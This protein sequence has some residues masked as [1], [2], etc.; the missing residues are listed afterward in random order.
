M[1]GGRKMILVWCGSVM[2]MVMFCGRRRLK[3]WFDDGVEK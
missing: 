3:G 2:E 1:I